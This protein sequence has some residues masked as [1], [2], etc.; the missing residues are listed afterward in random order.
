MGERKVR[1]LKQRSAVILG[2]SG[3]DIQTESDSFINVT[4]LTIGDGIDLTSDGEG[5]LSLSV[6][7]TSFDSFNA[8]MDGTLKEYTVEHNL[9]RFITTARVVSPDG[10]SAEVGIEN[11]DE[12]GNL[13]LNVAK[14]TSS[15]NM[16]GTLMLM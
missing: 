11:Q 1:F 13:S 14:I 6:E 4:S 16:L 9:G 10:L 5:N 7:T 3:I 12:S 15:V 8:E 2:K